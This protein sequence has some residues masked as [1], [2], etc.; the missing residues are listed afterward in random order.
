MVNAHWPTLSVEQS[1]V[2]DCCYFD[3]Q[4]TGLV[5]GLHAN[6]SHYNMLFAA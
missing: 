4:Y 1:T 5:S 6:N 3:T 2:W